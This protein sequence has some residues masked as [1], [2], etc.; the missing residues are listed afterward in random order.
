MFNKDNSSA[1]S[2][3]PIARYIII[4]IGV[5]TVLFIIF[6]SYFIWQFKLS[7]NI[8]KDLND[9]HVPSIEYLNQIETEQ[10]KLL[11]WLYRN[12]LHTADELNSY[13]N[14]NEISTL[15][16]SHHNITEHSLKLLFDLHTQKGKEQF[17]TA[18]AD[19]EQSAEKSLSSI[20]TLH[21]NRNLGADI[22]SGSLE[23][24]HASLSRL[25][26]QHLQQQYILLEQL[27]DSKSFYKSSI[28]IIFILLIIIGSMVT[29]RIMRLIQAVLTQQKESTRA[30]AK[31]KS[32]LDLTEDCVFIFSVDA[33]L[34]TYANQGALNQVKYSYDELMQMH[35]YDIK[36]TYS[37]N[38]FKEL[39]RS[40]IST[41]NNSITFETIHQDKYG[42]QLPVEI[43]LQYIHPKNEEAR[44]V[45][46]VR[47]ITARKQTYETINFLANARP[48]E[49]LKPFLQACI[50]NLTDVYHSKCAFIGLLIEPE[51][52][53]IRTLAIKSGNHYADNFEYPVEET[54]C[55]DILNMSKR[56][57]KTNVMKFY[58]KDQRLTNMELD[59]YFGSPLI[60]STGKVIGLVAV[61]DS[62][63][64]NLTDDNAAILDVF[65]KRI[66]TELE[67]NMALSDL[68]TQQQQ[69]EETVEKR[70]IDLKTAKQA[71][72]NASKS[73]SVFLSN[74]SHE[75][76][77]PMNAILGFA[78]I[79]E[80]D[81][82]TDDEKQNV[83]EI[84][85]AGEH[86][87]E[88]INEVLDLTKIEAGHLNL[89]TDCVGFNELMSDCISIIEP[90][91]KKHGLNLINNIP[92]TREFF[93]RIDFTRA[94][95]VLLNLMSNAVK[96]NRVDGY[97]GLN[98]E[99]LQ[100]SRRIR[101]SVSDAGQGLSKEQ[102]AKLFKPFERAGAEFSNI[103]GTGI[104]L[105][106]SKQ[107]VEL[108]GGDIGLE[109]TPGSGSTF[110]VEFQMVE[111]KDI[112]AIEKEKL[113]AS[114]IPVQTTASAK[115][116][117]I[118]YIEDNPAN[119]RLIQEFLKRKEHITLETAHEPVLG[120]DIAKNTVP[121][122]ILLD[123]NL[124]G[125]NGYEVL[126]ILRLTETLRD[127]PVIAI[128]ANAMTSDI[129]H[130]L[131]AGFDHYLSKPVQLVEFYAVIDKFLPPSG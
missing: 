6:I 2:P 86:L 118:L 58:P 117:K 120:L 53:H 31:F 39:V 85:K 76:R 60:T 115:D 44:Y 94:K 61:L 65:S 129:R 19:V 41:K 30:L 69:L 18:I 21:Q 59:S 105:V 99:V 127:I 4:L 122:L 64:L 22:L 62:K 5:L 75:L 50:S 125:M 52:T 9:Y 73:K 106:I 119:L 63:E 113:T 34:F 15:L 47:D 11:G 29:Y 35:P 23:R 20:I 114:L 43:F 102:Q 17:K 3:E 40:L 108:M 126:K 77:T 45:A 131:E 124:P 10:H 95:Q 81:A 92:Q 54:P 16:A 71:A 103:E 111:E 67:R 26:N 36:P 7:E 84:L 104:G 38:E 56:M 14:Q 110:W 28:F 51:R 107:L 37:K 49:N 72:E 55:E 33:L 80:L 98:L 91:A 12:R 116:K 123:I 88:L 87:L 112:S 78:Q 97:I 128:S 57:I 66:A 83:T 27:I 68:A 100:A 130:G 74:M 42:Q 13:S 82:K 93:V 79:I 1:Y 70:T 48:T 90:L 89:S 46:I 8:E 101:F 25:K 96:Y 109:S 32:T 121:D 24:F